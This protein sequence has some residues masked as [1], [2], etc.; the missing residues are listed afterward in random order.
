LQTGALAG[1][2]LLLEQ[3]QVPDAKLHV[4]VVPVQAASLPAEH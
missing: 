3:P 1:H 4:G 2:S